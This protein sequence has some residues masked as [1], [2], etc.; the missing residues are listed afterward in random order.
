MKYAFGVNEGKARTP[1]ILRSTRTWGRFR[2]SPVSQ[3]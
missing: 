2:A 1:R 3:A